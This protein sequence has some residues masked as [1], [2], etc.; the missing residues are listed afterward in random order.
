MSKRRIGLLLAAI[1]L[2][3][4]AH[5]ALAQTYSFPYVGVRLTD[6]AGWTVL[7]PDALDEQAALLAALD[8]DADVL[9]ADYAANHTVFE[10]Y[11][12]DAVQVSLTAVATEDTAAWADVT[13]MTEEQKAYFFATYEQP[14]YEAAQWSQ[15]HPGMIRSE[16]RFEADG[17]AVSFAGLSTVRQ[18]TLFTLTASGATAAMDALHAANEAVLEGL[19]FLG[20]A[21]EMDADE[22]TL[23]IPDAI[24]DDGAN[25]PLALEDFW[26]IT[27]EDT[28]TIMLRTIA[29]AEVVLKTATDALRG[30]SDEE[31][32]FS[33][34]VS[35]RRETAYAYTLTA[36]AEGRAASSMEV[37]VERRLSQDDLSQAYRRNAKQIDVY[38]YENLASAPE[39]Y[40]GK[41][42]TLRGNVSAFSEI[43]GFPCA[44]I[45]TVNPGRGVWLN[46]VWVMLTEAVT[47]VEGDIRTVYGDVRGDALPYTDE[48][49]NERLAPVVIGRDILT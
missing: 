28:T 23:T 31:G 14:P 40:A 25:T 4:G 1:L 37:T 7:L 44:L 16:W 30:R 49:G 8:V 5:T 42:V 46:P 22:E 36:Q 47:L 35:T 19:A 29:D 21:L 11:M 27:Y 12:Q 17:T 3:T 10:I 20:M 32:R 38:G 24:A 18:G 6:Q 15:A 41:S 34:R 48:D 33:F 13:T 45:Y 39:A 26:P 2:I 43:G 9:A